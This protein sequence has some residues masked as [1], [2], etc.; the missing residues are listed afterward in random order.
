MGFKKKNI[1]GLSTL[2]SLLFV[3]YLFIKENDYIISFNIKAA[4]GTVF[5]GVNEW[6]TAQNTNQSE[7][8]SLLEKNNFDY[9]K[10]EMIKGQ[11]HLQYTWNL[12]PINDSVTN[13]KVG[14]K[15]MQ[16][17]LYN[18]L[19]VPFF[20]TEFKKEQINK[21]KD[22]KTG[23][24]EHIKKFKIK[25]DGEGTSEE[26][27]VAYISLKSVLQEKARNMIANDADIT[28]FLY[29]NKISIIDSPYLEITNWNYETETLDFNYCFP[30]HKNTKIIPDELVKFKTI[31]AMKGLKATYYGNFRTSDRAWFALLDYAKRHDYKLQ[32]KVL[33]HFMANP[34]NGGN[35]LSWETKIIIPFETK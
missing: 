22:F 32:N 30:I 14:I 5:Q 19:T 7:N 33:E 11:N 12:N 24:D 4:T 21:I 35:E 10:K 25:I 18:R 2:F 28:G 1:I 17:S 29:R 27:F 13:V 26:I 16:H 9:I 34:F 3:W 23:L 8:Y 15:D 31:P 20:K 6:T